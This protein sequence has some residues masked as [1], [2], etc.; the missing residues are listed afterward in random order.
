MSEF[1]QFYEQFLTR[2]EEARKG[3]DSQ[4][5]QKLMHV[6][7]PD[8]EKEDQDIY[9]DFC[10]TKA[11]LYALFG[12]NLDLDD[13]MQKALQF[14]K[15]EMFSHL[16]F[17]WLLLYWHQ[18]KALKQESKIN[19]NFSAIYNISEQAINME[20]DE[21]QQ[22]A[23]QSM[24]ILS[25]AALGKHEEVEIEMN[26]ISFKQIP[27]K[28]VNDTTKIQYFYANIYKMLVAALEIRN[29]GLLLKVLNMITLDDLVI[30][31]KDP[32][33][34]KFNTIVMDIAD[35]RPEF[36]ADFNYFYQMRKQWAGFLPNFSLFTMMIEEGNQKGLQLFFGSMTK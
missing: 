36:A 28:L 21:Y 29:E 7:E 26:Q 17:K 16:Y 5:F 2:I 4:A 33:F 23:F 10:Q 30:L 1:K 25:L 31:S 9:A 12:E 19:A 6:V 8:W 35:I 24:R 34:R 14:S 11:G 13:W 32:V 3:N 15:P 18:L 27:I 20:K 22:K